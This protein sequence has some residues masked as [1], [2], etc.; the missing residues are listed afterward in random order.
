MSNKENAKCSSQAV[1]QTQ[2]E[3]ERHKLPLK[4]CNAWDTRCPP[5][6]SG[7]N[8]GVRQ[9]RCKAD[10]FGLLAGVEVCWLMCVP[11]TSNSR[12]S[13]NMSMTDEPSCKAAWQVVIF[14]PLVF[15]HYAHFLQS[16]GTANFWKPQKPCSPKP[17]EGF[18]LAHTRN[19][20]QWP[21]WFPAPLL[22][23]WGSRS[24]PTTAGGGRG[25]LAGSQPAAASPLLRKA[26][27]AAESFAGGSRQGRKMFSPSTNT[28][29][30]TDARLQKC[31]RN[32]TGPPHAATAFG[33]RGQKRWEQSDSFV[34]WK[35]LSRNDG[36]TRL[37]LYLTVT[38][39]KD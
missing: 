30:S 34:T 4:D 31:V 14:S 26:G 22:L 15:P 25:S 17:A 37:H 12:F 5:L 1:R 27:R 20:Q 18:I 19:N 6:A 3:R 7:Q 38:T 39:G 36:K 10:C 2:G 32:P 35:S 28:A 11:V 21:I 13:L 23:P 8:S 29:V 16:R 33:S 9:G 24:T